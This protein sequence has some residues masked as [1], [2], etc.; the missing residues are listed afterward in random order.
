MRRSGEYAVNAEREIKGSDLDV[1][2][3]VTMQDENAIED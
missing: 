3:A 1:F 2:A